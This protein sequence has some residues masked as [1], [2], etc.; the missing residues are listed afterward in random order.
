VEQHAPGNDVLDIGSHVRS[1]RV[2][3]EWAWHEPLDTIEIIRDGQVAATLAC[4]ADETHGLW[5]TT[6]EAS[7]GWLAARMWGRRRTS[8]GHALWA[9]TSPV[10]LRQLAERDQVRAASQV[11]LERI[12]T[13]VDWLARS[14]RFSGANQRE[15]ML[16]LF[17]EGRSA[18]EALLA[19]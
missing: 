4:P 7:G 6:L 2:T 10:Y 13:A 15:R 12:D 3:I 17:A 1:L 19:G 5:T 11:F 18:Y 14:A 9:H 16:Q 8:Y